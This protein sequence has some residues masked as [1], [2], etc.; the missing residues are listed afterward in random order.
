MRNLRNKETILI[1]VA[2]VGIIALSF[3]PTGFEKQ[4]YKNSTSAVAKVIGINNSN[5]Y[6]TGMI[7]QGHQVCKLEIVNGNHK[8]TIIEGN[9]L[10]SGKLESDK[11]FSIGDKALILIEKGEG[12]NIIGANMIEHYRVNKIV[13]LILLFFIL[14]II[15]CGKT[16]FRTIL[17]FIFT[18]VVI[19]KVLI[20]VLLRGYNPTFVGLLVGASISLI[21][22]ILV[23]G[24]TKRT[25]CAILGAFVASLITCA[26]SII[27]SDI[28]KID[29]V[30][31]QW[32]ESL[33]YAGFE[34]LNLTSI[35]K[36]G[37][38]LSCSGAILDLSIDISAAIEELVANNPSIRKTEI[39]KSGMN[40]S[41][42][43]LGTQTTTLLLAYM[44]SFICVMMVYMAQG[45]PFMNILNSQW[46][47]SEIVHTFVGCIGLIIVCPVTTFIC[48]NLYSKKSL[49]RI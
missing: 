46:I 4:M 11:I 5:I 15:C 16:G 38:Y 14:L 9:N 31:M 7:K 29:G 22:L 8:G 26:L 20:P 39:L 49:S 35:Y 24:F 21:T 3:I 30:V 36:A 40:I 10:L 19:W 25:Y 17:S 47:S 37:I 45:T 32:S 34:N 28:F 41:K 27:W 13:V 33:L 48:G 12:G 43:V 18:I 42:S 6:N 44:G 23:S 1:I 2:I